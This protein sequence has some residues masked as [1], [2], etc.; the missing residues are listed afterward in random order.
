MSFSDLIPYLANVAAGF[1]LVGFTFRNPLW[2]RSFA[3]LGNLTFI[4]YYFL[5]SNVPLWT[6]IVSAAAIIA[7]NLWMMWKIIRDKRSFNLSADEM[8]LFSRLPGVTPGQFKQLL[9]IA[10]WYHPDYE[11]ALT[12]E[13]QTPLALNYV[14]DGKVRV[15]KAGTRF[16][17]GPN[18]FIGELSFLRKQP[19][20]ADTTAEPGTLLVA[21]R[22]DK[23]RTLMSSN[24]GIRKAM[25]SLLLSDVADKISRTGLP[26]LQE[27]SY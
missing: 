19:A 5:V 10:E 6:A 4:C 13:G 14:L 17:V 3:I 23:L 12:K 11:F 7:V 18:A 26:V 25:D 22:Q 20:T 15:E 24:D 21:W 9:A 16:H 27:Q 8:L 1:M 2:L